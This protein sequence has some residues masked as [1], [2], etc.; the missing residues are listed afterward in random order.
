M[1]EAQ[2]ILICQLYGNK[3]GEEPS[4]TNTN[5]LYHLLVFPPNAYFIEI[6]MF[7]KQEVINVLKVKAK[8]SLNKIRIKMSK[9]TQR[10]NVLSS[11][12]EFGPQD[13]HAGG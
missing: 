5:S 12:P 2:I 11:R 3:L 4:Q 10:L 1:A 9:M 13:L 8:I 7:G 6:F